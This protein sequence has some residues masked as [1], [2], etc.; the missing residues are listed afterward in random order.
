MIKSKLQFFLAAF[1]FSFVLSV[2]FMILVVV[3]FRGN[4]HSISMYLTLFPILV[5]CFT[6]LV[7][8]SKICE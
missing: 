4:G 2:I 8:L 3:M 5:F 1:K 7:Y 6:L